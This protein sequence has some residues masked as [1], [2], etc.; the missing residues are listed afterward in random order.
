MR[1]HKDKSGYPQQVYTTVYGFGPSWR[2]P[3]TPSH[4]VQ[5]STAQLLTKQS[6]CFWEAKFRAPARQPPSSAIPRIFR[7]V[8]V[9]FHGFF[10]SQ[11]TAQQ[12]T[13]FTSKCNRS[14]PYFRRLRPMKRKSYRG[15]VGAFQF[16]HFCL[17]VFHRIIKYSFHLGFLSSSAI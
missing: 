3:Y 1:I 4:F 14:G 9:P 12:S 16:V 13:Q 2:G 11:R 5:T 10:P 7:A 17:D 8:G 6:C 15:N